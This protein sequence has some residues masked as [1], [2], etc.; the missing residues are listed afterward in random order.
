MADAKKLN[1][2]LAALAA[3]ILV[4]SFSAL[5]YTLVPKGEA[6]VL[7]VNGTEYAWADIFNDFE[8]YNFAVDDM[9]YAGISIEELLLDAGVEN[10]ETHSYKFTARDTYKQD[11]AWADIQE[12][13]IIESGPAENDFHRAIFPGTTHSFWVYDLASIEV[14]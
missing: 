8:L 10:P 5:A 3:V 11:V 4:V 6:D 13:Y 1:T 7:V 2:I 9:D 14:I 12:G